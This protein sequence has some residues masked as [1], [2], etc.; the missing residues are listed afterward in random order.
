MSRLSGPRFA[1][2]PPL[3]LKLKGRPLFSMICTRSHRHL[4]TVI[5]EGSAALPDTLLEGESVT[6]GLFTAMV[7]SVVMCE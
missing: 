7:A 2:K 1:Y 4:D 3:D 6:C 5:R